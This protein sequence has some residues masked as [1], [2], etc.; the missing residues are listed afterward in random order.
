M[1]DVFWLEEQGIPVAYVDTPGRLHKVTRDGPVFVMEYATLKY[2]LP[3]VTDPDPDRRRAA[4]RK[5]FERQ[6]IYRALRL[7]GAKVGDRVRLL[8]AEFTLDELPMPSK[9][10]APSSDGIPDYPYVLT[11]A[12]GRLEVEE[13]K[14]RAR[15]LLPRVIDHLV[16]GRSSS[17][18]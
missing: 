18:S 13:V 2:I 15:E 4:M 12:I 11:S 10:W 5:Q 14:E 7:A 1:H 6:G 17:D 3:Q 16:G 9:Q 8:D